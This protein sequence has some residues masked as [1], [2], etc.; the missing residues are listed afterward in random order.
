MEIAWPWFTTANTSRWA[1]EPALSGQ[2]GAVETGGTGVFGRF[3]PRDRGE[4]GMDGISRLL[5]GRTQ[6]LEEHGHGHTLF[7]QTMFVPAEVSNILEV[8]RE[9]EGAL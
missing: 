9:I 6:L 1:N 8:S 3:R 7:H 5:V 2:T 4:K